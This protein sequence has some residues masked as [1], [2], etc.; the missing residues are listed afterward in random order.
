MSQRT[1]E[2]CY[3]VTDVTILDKIFYKTLNLSVQKDPE[4]QLSYFKMIS[5]I[6]L[7]FASISNTKTKN[8]SSLGLVGQ[9]FAVDV[10]C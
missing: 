2:D 7:I 1:A 4:P 5:N 9:V 8:W 10:S 6:V 3:I